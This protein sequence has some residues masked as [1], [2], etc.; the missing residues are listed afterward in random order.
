[1]HNKLKENTPPQKYKM[2]PEDLR[3]EAR[4][5]LARQRVV[6]RTKIDPD[7]L[8]RHIIEA[9]P[10]DTLMDRAKEA[11]RIKLDVP[12]ETWTAYNTCNGTTQYAVRAALKCHYHCAYVGVLY[13]YGEKNQFELHYDRDDYDLGG[14]Y[15]SEDDSM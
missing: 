11:Y 9:N 4:E 15:S 3:R 1:L 7:D 6:D 10:L 2:T 13:L 8:A 5:T 12:K 14:Y